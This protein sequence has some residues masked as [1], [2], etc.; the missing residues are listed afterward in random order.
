[1]I[2]TTAETKTALGY[3]VFLLEPGNQACRQC[4]QLSDKQTAKEFFTIRAA[5]GKS[6]PKR[7]MVPN[8][9]CPWEATERR[10]CPFFAIK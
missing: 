5:F 4:L 9:E 1:M 7:N 10:L 2:M 6:C 8:G 3:C